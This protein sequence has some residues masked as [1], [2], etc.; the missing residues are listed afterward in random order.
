MTLTLE[1]LPLTFILQPIEENPSRRNC[2]EAIKE[3]PNGV[4]VELK[5][6]TRTIE[7]NRLLW[8]LLTLWEKFQKCSVNGESVSLGREFWKIILLHSYRKNHKKPMLIALGLDGD[9]VP[10]GYS[11]KVMGVRDFAGFLTFCLAESGNRG[12]ELPPL[13]REECLGYI[14]KYSKPEPT[15]RIA[16]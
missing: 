3:L 16:A 10:L 2:W 14:R 4:V 12:M 5:E 1:D 13:A 8:P 6:E 7:Q 15:G 9:L 11:S